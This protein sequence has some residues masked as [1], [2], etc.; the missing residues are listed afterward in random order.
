MSRIGIT[1]TI[2]EILVSVWFLLLAYRVVGKPPGQDPKYD[3]AIEDWSL[4]FKVIGFLGITM[5]VLELIVV[6][7]ARVG[8]G[9]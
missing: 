9:F 6:L 3:A 5:F 8:G 7:I 4:L 2:F 1:G